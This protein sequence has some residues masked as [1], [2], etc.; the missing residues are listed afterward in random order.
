MRRD[1]K[2]LVAEAQRSYS[3]Y[4]R[5]AGVQDHATARSGEELYILCDAYD[6]L[7]EALIRAERVDRARFEASRR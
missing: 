1:G 7:A 3:L 5:M 4:Q 6:A 2:V